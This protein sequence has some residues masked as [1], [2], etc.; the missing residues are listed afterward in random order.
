MD[1][2]GNIYNGPI[3]HGSGKIKALKIALNL[4]ESTC[5]Q[6]VVARNRRILLSNIRDSVKIS[7]KK[8]EKFQNIPNFNV[9]SKKYPQNPL[10]P[11]LPPR[12]SRVK[13]P[14]RPRRRSRPDRGG[15]EGIFKKKT[16]SRKFTCPTQCASSVPTSPE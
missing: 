4:K 5:E 1:P 6:N 11:V 7:K 12:N 15:A 16:N 9:L 2:L 14:V 3:P 13:P 10:Q 8:T